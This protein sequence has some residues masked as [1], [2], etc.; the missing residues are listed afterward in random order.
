M[1]VTAVRPKEKYGILKFE[2]NSHRVTQLDET[3]R[4]SNIYINGGYFVF[5]KKIISSIKKNNIF[6]EQSPLKAIIKKKRLYAFQ[7]NGFWKSL[8][9]LK[10]KN[11]FNKIINNGKKPWLI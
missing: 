11:D 3:K 1:T 10:D 5:S 4:K 9:T 2:P 8:D 6:F 7:H